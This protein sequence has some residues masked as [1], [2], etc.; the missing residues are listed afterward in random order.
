VVC[1]VKHGYSHLKDLLYTFKL[2]LFGRTRRRFP[3]R[4]LRNLGR[5]FH[6]WFC[7]FRRFF[8]RRFLRRIG[9]FFYRRLATGIGWLSLRAAMRGPALRRFVVI[10]ILLIPDR[11]YGG[12]REFSI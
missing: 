11:E 8:D 9:W 7:R 1:T 3:R 10:V 6:R 5:F 12:A 4:L 2:L